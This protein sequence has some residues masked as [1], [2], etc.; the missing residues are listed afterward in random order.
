MR[1]IAGIAKGTKLLSPKGLHTRP[2]SDR[3]KE[4][5]F[6][7]I[8]DRASGARA[9]DLFA[10][11]GSLGIEALSRGAQEV[12][13]VESSPKAV[14][15]IRKNL[16][17]TAFSEKGIVFKGFAKGFL[18]DLAGKNKKFELIF[19]DPPYKIDFNVLNSI[20]KGIVESKALSSCGLIVLEYSSRRD[21]VCLEEGLEL[22]FT[23]KYGE[24]SLSFYE[25]IR[26][27]KDESCNLPR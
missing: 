3:I 16:K 14:D 4:A 10:G 26:K 23:R 12:T 19:L 7:I 6:N 9:L 2:T 5:L 1:V 13:F 17:K 15:A 24:G 11:S 25:L 21:F 18:K 8:A 22:R 20:F 27:G